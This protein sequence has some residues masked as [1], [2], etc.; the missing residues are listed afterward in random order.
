MHFKNL[1][2]NNFCFVV[3]APTFA[4]SLQHGASGKGAAG[5]TAAAS[6]CSGA[7]AAVNNCSSSCSGSSGSGSG[8]S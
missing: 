7:A 5:S 8:L 3:T 4:Q 6:G 2:N 1:S